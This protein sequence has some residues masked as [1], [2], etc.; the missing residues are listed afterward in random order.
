MGVVFDE[1]VGDIQPDDGEP[2]AEDRGTPAPPQVLDA[3]ELRRALERTRRRDARLA[4]D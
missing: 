2:G 4:A 3:D 1:V